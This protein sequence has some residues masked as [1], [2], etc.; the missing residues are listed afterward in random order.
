MPTKQAK[1]K[2]Y[3]LYE[4]N[5]GPSIYL[6]GCGNAINFFYKAIVGDYIRGVQAALL[7]AALKILYDS[8]IIA[9]TKVIQELKAHEEESIARTWFE[10]FEEITSGLIT[11]VTYNPIPCFG[12][13]SVLQEIFDKLN[14]TSSK[15][16][17]NNYNFLYLLGINGIGKTTIM[18]QFIE[19]NKEY[20]QLIWWFRKGTSVEVQLRRLAQKLQLKYDAINGEDLARLIKE[21]LKNVVNYLLIFDDAKEIHGLA[22]NL[23]TDLH[24]DGREHHVYLSNNIDP[25]GGE[26]SPFPGYA[27]RVSGLDVSGT[28]QLVNYLKGSLTDTQQ[29]RLH[30]I[31]D[32][33]TLYTNQAVVFLRESNNDVN[34][35][36][37]SLNKEQDKYD[38]ILNEIIKKL[39]D[40]DIKT[41]ILFMFFQYISTKDELFQGLQFDTNSLDKLKRFGLLIEKPEEREQKTFHIH[42]LTLKYLYRLIFQS[43]AQDL[44]QIISQLLRFLH[45]KFDY[46]KYA[47]KHSDA[48]DLYFSC[49]ISFLNSLNQFSDLAHNTSDKVLDPYI[50]N[51]FTSLKLTSLEG[52]ELLLRVSFYYLNIFR[53]YHA[54]SIFAL[55]A[56]QLALKEME[57]NGDGEKLELFQAEGLHNYAINKLFEYKTDSN[58]LKS[59]EVLNSLEQDLNLALEIFNSH[60]TTPNTVQKADI[61]IT[62]GYLYKQ[63]AIDDSTHKQTY[64]ATALLHFS[65]ALNSCGVLQTPDA[66]KQLEDHELARVKSLAYHASGNLKFT[67][68]MISAALTDLNKALKIRTKHLPELSLDL[69]RTKQKLALI[70]LEQ[71]SPSIDSLQE[72]QRL[73]MS[74]IDIQRRLCMDKEHP[75]F[76]ETLDTS[77]KIKTALQDKELEQDSIQLMQT[78]YSASSL[79]PARRRST[80]SRQD[81]RRSHCSLFG[82]LAT[83]ST[84]PGSPATAT[85]LSSNYAVSAPAS[86]SLDGGHGS[87]QSGTHRNASELDSDSDTEGKHNDKRVRPGSAPTSPRH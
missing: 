70:M 65:R 74:A 62:L 51:D 77:N 35:F 40:I 63:K 58:E 2:K 23:K 20:Y 76:K 37:N 50:I 33:H 43:H 56:A 17:T 71:A 53:N 26:G 59:V 9:N 47:T 25:P 14:R 34:D 75:N 4:F 46:T 81:L 57:T 31:L 78:S 16:F 44:D 61:Y 79:S 18:E 8:S 72:A 5:S 64:E 30:E 82:G 15:I 10:I 11:N 69:A 3:A 42:S 87:E 60:D 39:S 38:F 55:K 24:I 83:A 54:A 73:C 45:N 49:V 84:L 7:V 12:R 6:L 28:R 13:E 80:L 36:L 27:V 86:L 48:I 66:E 29:K 67:I 85:N 1:S 41:L 19:N 22:S 32:G 52:A 68:G 21:R